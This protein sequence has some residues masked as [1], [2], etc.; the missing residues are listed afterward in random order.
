MNI[1]KE[2]KKYKKKGF[3]DSQLEQIKFG[4]KNGLTKE[5]VDIY[6]KDIYKWEQMAY[7]RM[8]LEDGLEVEL[9]TDVNY[10]SSQMDVIY[11][12]LQRGLTKV[13]LQKYINPLYNEQQLKE[14]ISYILERKAKGV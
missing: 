2:L 1:E 6:A 3:I 8:G 9:Y 5:Q 11:F 7:I 12:A 13:I 10:T 4:F 14:I